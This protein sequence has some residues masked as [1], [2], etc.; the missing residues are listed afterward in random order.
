MR[1]LAVLKMVRPKVFCVKYPEP[2]FVHLGNSS[3]HKHPTENHHF[4][5]ELILDHMVE[6]TLL[7]NLR[8]LPLLSILSRYFLAPLT[9]RVRRKH[10]GYSRAKVQ[11]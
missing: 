8:R 5:L 9:A 6:V 2:N 4:W 1:V 3:D 7:D 10:V 11:K